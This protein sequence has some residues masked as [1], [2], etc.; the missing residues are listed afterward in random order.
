MSSPIT[1]GKRYVAWRRKSDADSDLTSPEYARA[2]FEYV[3]APNSKAAA[4][5][6]RE[7]R[8]ASSSIVIDPAS[9]IGPPEWTQD[10]FRDLW[11]RVL[12]TYVGKVVFVEGWQYSNGCAYEYLIAVQ[13]GIAAV[14]TQEASIP[15]NIAIP[16]LRAAI[17]EL[18]ES[19]IDTGFLETV[20]NQLNS[21]VTTIQQRGP[22]AG[23]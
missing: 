21:L 3:I 23:T 20:T 6:V 19:G 11:A 22:S 17:S 16:M 9:F 5:I 10:D 18:N 15:L 14:D 1:T 13:K 12:G 7:I 8:Q 4:K 2:H